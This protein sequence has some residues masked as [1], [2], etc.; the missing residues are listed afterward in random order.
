M[1]QY[2]HYYCNFPIN[3]KKFLQM[4]KLHVIIV[5][6]FIIIASCID[7]YEDRIIGVWNATNIETDRKIAREKKA[8]YHRRLREFAR[9]LSYSFRLDSVYNKRIES[10]LERGIY[11]VRGDYL[12]LKPENAKKGDSLFIEKLSTDK[13]ILTVDN[14][15]GSTMKFYFEKEQYNK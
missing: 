4:R 1:L 10:D 15:D 14:S 2:F 6:T 3:F 13:L 5:F 12:Y 9:K 11:D 8:E 7:S